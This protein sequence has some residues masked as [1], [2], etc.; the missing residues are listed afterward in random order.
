MS[1]NRRTFFAAGATALIL[2]MAAIPAEAMPAPDDN[3][4]N[5]PQ[6]LKEVANPQI[7]DRVQ[8]PGQFQKQHLKQF[9][10]NP[11][12]QPWKFRELGVENQ[13]R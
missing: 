1:M 8:V 13:S 4:E 10:V 9:K 11:E 7:T 2:S 5:W 6:K 3:M 12:P